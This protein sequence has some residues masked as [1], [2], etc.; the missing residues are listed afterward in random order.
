M[1]VVRITWTC[2]KSFS[3][4]NLQSR[5]NCAMMLIFDIWVGIFRNGKL[6]PEEIKNKKLARTRGEFPSTFLRKYEVLFLI[7]NKST[8]N[9]KQLYSN[10][11]KLKACSNKTLLEKL[12]FSWW[13]SQFG[14]SIK[15]FLE[16]IVCLADPKRMQ[17]AFAKNEQIWVINKW[18]ENT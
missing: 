12:K 16:N 2:Q 7:F 14:V 1:V 6:V 9:F 3:V 13:I 18:L 4:L 5:L 15:V 11:G 10:I 17:R 8:Q